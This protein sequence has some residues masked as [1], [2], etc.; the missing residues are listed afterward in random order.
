MLNPDEV[1][2]RKREEAL[3]ALQ[4]FLQHDL[5]RAGVEDVVVLLAA[6][7]ARP[8]WT[9][10]SNNWITIDHLR[11]AREKEAIP[12][13]ELPTK[14]RLIRLR[15]YDQNETPTWYFPGE[16]ADTVKH[17]IWEET[18]TSR[19]FY[20]LGEKPLA[21]SGGRKSKQVDP[22]ASFTL[23]SLLEVL[24]VAIQPDDKVEVWAY[25][26]DQWRQMSFLTKEMTRLPL[27]LELARKMDEYAM[28]IGPWIFPEEWEEEENEEGDE[29]ED[30]GPGLEQLEL[31]S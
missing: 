13:S 30:E 20:N 21:M 12:L 5:S 11:F 19:L 27:P 4:G 16:K 7:N 26:V 10:I 22:G 23:P 6:Q 9:G 8:T 14:I 17:G 25:A 15:T 31:F 18:T 1:K 28:V 3:Q 29:D 2:H 24:P